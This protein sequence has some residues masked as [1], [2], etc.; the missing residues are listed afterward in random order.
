MFAYS[1]HKNDANFMLLYSVWKPA[2]NSF[3][4]SGKSNGMRLVS[5][6]AAIRKMTKLK[7]CGN[8]PS[9]TF[10]W[11]RLPVCVSTIV[12]RLK[13]FESSS[14][15]AICRQRHQ[16][17]LIADHLGRTAQTSQERVL[18]VRKTTPASAMP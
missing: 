1:G 10:Q 13:L 9:K 15:A 16:R 7:I 11:I 17:Q 6:N 18:I 2:T 4:A 12:L 14:G 5:A 8:G 3:S